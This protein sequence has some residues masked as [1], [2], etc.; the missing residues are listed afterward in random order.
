MI[1]KKFFL[2]KTT[3]VLMCDKNHFIFIIMDINL[4]NNIIQTYN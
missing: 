2:N 1:I 3:I 4:H